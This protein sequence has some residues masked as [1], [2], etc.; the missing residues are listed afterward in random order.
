[1]SLKVIKNQKI[2]Q[3]KNNKREPRNEKEKSKSKEKQKETRKNKKK[4]KKRKKKY[5]HVPK[6]QHNNTKIFYLI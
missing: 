2:K 6:M 4:K 5:I 1:M 3:T